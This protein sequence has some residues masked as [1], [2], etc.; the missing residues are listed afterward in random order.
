MKFTDLIVLLPAVD[1][2]YSLTGFLVVL[3][4][5]LWFVRSRSP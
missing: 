2:G 4:V 1:N 5:W 3:V